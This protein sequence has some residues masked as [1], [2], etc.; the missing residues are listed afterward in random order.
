MN[1]LFFFGELPPNA[2]NGISLSN[3]M[4]LSILKEYFTIK[5]V[6]EIVPL[7]FHNKFS[8]FKLFLQVKNITYA[9]KSL[10]MNKYDYLYLSYPV[11]LMG[12]IKILIL[13]IF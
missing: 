7:K 1:N 11:S 3:E 6:E 9:I 10:F 5:I 2:V 4:N 13:I 8:M 12:S